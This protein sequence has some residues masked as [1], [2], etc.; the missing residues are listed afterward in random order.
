MPVQRSRHIPTDLS[1]LK[2]YFL[3]AASSLAQDGLFGTPDEVRDVIS[4]HGAA[5]RMFILGTR[6]LAAHLIEAQKHGRYVIAAVVDDLLHQSESHYHGIPLIT[7]SAFIKICQ[8]KNNIFA[9]N[10]CGQKNPKVFFNDVCSSN[11]IPHMNFEQAVRAFQ[12]QGLVDHRMDDWGPHIIRNT[13]RYQ[14]L[15]QRM[16]DPFS[17]KTLYSILNFRLTCHHS[18]YYRIEQSY[19]SLY[20]ES[21]LLH[22]GNEE[23]M[24]DCGA[25][26]GESL[27]GFLNATNGIF[28]RNWLIEPDRFN[29]QTLRNILIEDI[30]PTLASRISIHACGAGENSCRL[31]FQ[32]Q[33]GHGSSI[34]SA[35]CP[36]QE[37]EFIDV[38]PIDDIV[39]EAPTFIKMDVEGH[40]LPALRGAEQTLKS[41]APKLAIST[42][43]RP[44]D[45]LD[46]TDYIISQQ[47]GYKI[48]LRHHGHYRWDTC[49]Y[50]Y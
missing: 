37:S 35:N 25:S 43:H 21:G 41:S 7:T 14:A 50:F 3:Q 20:F 2:D 30:H 22:F 24:V 17:A 18:H 5:S 13:E 12:L 32:H 4:N 19:S 38:H 42:Y 9:V 27:Y 23:R 1:A 45:L 39:D 31:A 34:Q 8:G 10:T 47:P 40:E 36:T 48:G 28:S 26:I 29:I 49:L 44:S 46:L 16:A 15:A 6:G 33:G 11:H